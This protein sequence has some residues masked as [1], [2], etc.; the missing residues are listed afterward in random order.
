MNSSFLMIID[1]CDES[2]DQ[3]IMYLTCWFVI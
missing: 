2:D 1:D 3:S